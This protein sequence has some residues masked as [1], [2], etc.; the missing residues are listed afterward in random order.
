MISA[1][2]VEAPVGMEALSAHRYHEFWGGLG[3]ILNHV[4]WL[5]CYG[6]LPSMKEGERAF[7]TVSSHNPH[8]HELFLWH[9]KAAQITICNIGFHC[10]FQDPSS[11]DPLKLPRG[12]CFHSLPGGPVE[13]Y[14]HPSDGPAIDDARGLGR[15]LIF[16]CASAEQDK[17]VPQPI[18]DAAAAR[19]LA[20]GWSIVVL[21]RNYIHHLYDFPRDTNSWRKE[22]RIAPSGGVL[23]LVDRLTV[24][25]V[26]KVIQGATG[27]FTAHSAV[28]MAS[29]NMKKPTFVL[30][31]EF[32]K[33]TYLPK[34]GEPWQGYFHGAGNPNCENAWFPEYTESRMDRWLAGLKE[35]S[36]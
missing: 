1:R 26:M 20:A 21:G 17:Y 5:P 30:Y 27:V 23:D 3:D 4:Y 35:I 10:S 28:C 19:A 12:G 29:Y 2:I 15:Y 11:R 18:V 7:I 13:F 8:A 16:A 25:G 9:P 6:A 33:K 24:P 14:P 34:P 31:N 32:A 22:V 36:R